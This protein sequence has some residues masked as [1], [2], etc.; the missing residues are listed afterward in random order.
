M[1]YRKAKQNTEGDHASGAA[2]SRET[3]Q[4]MGESKDRAGSES[5]GEEKSLVGGGGWMQSGA[6][7]MHKIGQEEATGT[8]K[9]RPSARGGGED[10]MRGEPADGL[11]VLGR[12]VENSSRSSSSSEPELSSRSSSSP[13]SYRDEFLLGRGRPPPLPRGSRG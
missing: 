10:D 7:C 4:I 8:P 5:E 6:V 2:A 9:L 13:S 1:W 11:L 12:R 3:M